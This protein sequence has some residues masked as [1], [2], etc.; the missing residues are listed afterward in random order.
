M[1]TRSGF[2]SRTANDTD[3]LRAY[4]ERCDF[5]GYDPYDALNS[6]LLRDSCRGNKWA[7]IAC[8]QF[9]RRCPVNIRPLLLI[10]RG[11]N[12][13]ALG[14]FLEGY[15][16]LCHLNPKDVYLD[17]VRR[18]I[19]Y[20]EA[21]RMVTASGHGW[22]HNFDWQSRVFFVPKGTPTIVNSAFIGHA[23]LDVADAGLDPRALELALPI[24]AF[25]LNDLHRAAEGDHFCFSYTPLDQYAVHNANLL[26]ASL[27]IRLWKQTG[28]EVLRDAALSALAYSMRHQREDGS[29]YYSEKVGSHWIDSFHT[30]FN[31]E[32]IRRFIRAGEGG[33]WLAQYEL[34]RAY[35]RDTFFLFDGTPKYYHD[36]VFPIDIHSP[37]EAVAFFSE[38]GDDFGTLADRVLDWMLNNMRDKQG[39]FYFRKSRFFT[40]RIPYMRWGQA[41]AFRALTTWEL[42]RGT[43]TGQKR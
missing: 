17:S 21:T 12:P 7:R 29:W 20:L 6:P 27:L 37:A 42:L 32:A 18:L 9:L 14:L 39:Y 19:G 33:E 15:V 13:K 40:N 28:R 38:E 3:A 41:W 11:H 26:G 16:R 30:G 2:I 4:V 35:Y 34:G 10:P 25:I 23:L 36:R 22:G 31:L 8:I 43:G 5:S 24:A 1:T